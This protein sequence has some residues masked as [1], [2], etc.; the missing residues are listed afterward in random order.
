LF[1]KWK[2]G[3]VKNSD[4]RETKEDEEIMSGKE[5]GEKQKTGRG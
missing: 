4:A 2:Q 5:E 1:K 3:K